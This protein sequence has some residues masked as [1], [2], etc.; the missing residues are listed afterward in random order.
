MS[1]FILRWGQYLQF[2]FAF[3]GI[4]GYEVTSSIYDPSGLKH[5]PTNCENVVKVVFTFFSLC[6]GTK[7]S[8]RLCGNPVFSN[9]LRFKIKNSTSI[10][11]R[12]TLYFLLK[13]ALYSNI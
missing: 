9:N 3:P 11:L 12:G 10:I 1:Q 5:S 4:F 6:V 2:F 7:Y 13:N 8:I